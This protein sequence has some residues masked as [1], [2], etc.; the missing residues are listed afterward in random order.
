M[1]SFLRL[2]L[3]NIATSITELE[4][5]TAL[6]GSSGG[7]DTLFQK[8]ELVS[9]LRHSVEVL[10]KTKQN[11]KCKELAHLRQQLE[12]LLNHHLT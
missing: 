9:A 12:G 5:S 8:A 4:R 1:L 6:L 3:R 10:N 7:R 11:F 2:T